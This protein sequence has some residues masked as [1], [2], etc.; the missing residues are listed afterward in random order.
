MVS[1]TELEAIN[2]FRTATQAL[3][4]ASANMEENVGLRTILLK[5]QEGLQKLEQIILGNGIRRDV[6]NFI[7]LKNEQKKQRKA[8][9]LSK[10]EFKELRK[11]EK[12]RKKELERA[13]KAKELQEQQE[14]L[15]REMFGAEEAER[16]INT[17]RAENLAQTIER[18]MILAEAE[19]GEQ[20]K[21]AA[22][23]AKARAEEEKA[24]EE[25][26]K[27]INSLTE[28]ARAIE[29]AFSGNVGIAFENLSRTIQSF[30]VS[31]AIGD[32]T[33][34][35]ELVAEQIELQRGDQPTKA[36]AAQERASQEAWKTSQI[37]L[38]ETIALNLTGGGGAGGDGGGEGGSGGGGMSKV[39]N[40][41]A[42]LGKGIG[43]F[44][45]AIGKGA[46][47]ALKGLAIGFAALGKALIP[48]GK[49]IGLAI[50]G[51]LR[52]FA[53]GVMAFANP[54]VIGGLAVFTVGMIGLGAALRI[55][56][57]AF[58]AIAPIMIKVA[59]V[60]GNVLM[61][62]IREVPEIFRSIG[63]VIESVGMTVTA[64]IDAIGGAI[65]K[66]GE[67]FQLV[68]DGIQRVLKGIEGVIRG[69]GDTI[70]GVITSVAEGIATVVNSFKGPSLDEKTQAVQKLSN[71]DPTR[72][73]LTAA[74]IEA[75]G[76]A[77][78]SIG[79]GVKIPFFSK[80]SPVLGLLELAKNSGG[81]LDASSA[82]DQFVKNASLFEKGVD[83]DDS[84]IEGIE[85]VV[86]SLGSG[87]PN[88]L[89]AFSNAINAIN[90]LDMA[91]IG[92]LSKIN[93]PQVMPPTAAEYERIFKALQ[94]A[95]PST[96]EKVQ[97]FFSKV[98]GRSP[99]ED[100]QARTP[101]GAGSAGAGP[102]YGDVGGAP[103]LDENQ[104]AAER[105]RR[106]LRAAAKDVKGSRDE[107]RIARLK[108]IIADPNT[109]ARKKII[110]KKKLRNLE[111]AQKAGMSSENVIAAGGS[112]SAKV[113][114]GQVISS[115]PP[116][117][118]DY[119]GGPSGGV[120]ITTSAPTTNVNRYSSPVSPKPTSP[121]AET[122]RKI[123][124]F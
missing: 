77:L 119:G 30:E 85:K 45:K 54:L 23:R 87:D 11:R 120:N 101:R 103:A 14:E 114:Q 10:R 15:T 22:E 90:D 29:A 78:D 19:K 61:T 52:G 75:I 91:K 51:I 109:S 6:L 50:A 13:Q 7:I 68:G 86:K 80:E 46:G 108:A 40:G 118:G 48:L 31:G 82:I 20:D 71:I 117:A 55:A 8:A 64:I 99:R 73:Q 115:S 106:S 72:M 93:I 121:S 26:E 21:E 111:L 37:G 58:E 88:G 17:Q 113:R 67:G 39:G 36:E 9:G 62:A 4:R 104:M 83:I 56:A 81:I 49:G 94:T 3:T 96:I 47:L 116:S 105:E 60:I 97:G 41:I 53:S 65:R 2:N 122:L 63:Y 25:E 66:I 5:K 69:I 16:I 44:I 57:P 110:A 95:E 38:L 12:Q 89:N 34:G 33:A 107:R 92:L 24:R 79:G 59:D 27:K 123:K 100:R 74:G 84:V 98:F 124:D 112:M 43:A 18:D 76:E 32:V 1:R 42:S 102:A 70:S 28:A 35:L